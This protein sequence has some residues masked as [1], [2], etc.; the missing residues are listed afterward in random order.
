PR[1][2]L[3]VQGV[4]CL[5][6]VVAGRLAGGGFTAMV[7]FTAP[8]FWFFFLLAGASL[9]VLRIREPDLER[10]FRVPLYPLT[11]LVFCS[12]CGFMLWSSLSYVH[13]QELGGFN[14][15]WIGVAVLAIGVVLLKVLRMTMPARIATVQGSPE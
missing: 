15:A 1:V 6:L 12:V 13:S 10:P 7:E 2:A 14:A 11:P 3:I 4:A 8:V 5:A 9:I